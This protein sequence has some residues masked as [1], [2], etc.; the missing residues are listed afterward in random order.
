MTASDWCVFYKRGRGGGG[1]QI[2]RQALPGRSHSSRL[3]L[4]GCQATKDHPLQP[5]VNKHARQLK[6]YHLLGNT[7]C[8]RVYTQA[9]LRV[10]AI[11]CVSAHVDACVC[12]NLCIC[13]GCHSQVSLLSSALKIN[14][15]GA[16]KSTN[17]APGRA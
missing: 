7:G 10:S 11:K 3:P 9:D 1:C 16:R 2:A 5:Q 17:T 14:D 6:Y 8:V 13:V 12:G 4:I 15:L